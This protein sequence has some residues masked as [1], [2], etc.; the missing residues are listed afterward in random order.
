MAILYG[1]SDG[2]FFRAYH[3]WVW[4]FCA[5]GA[6]AFNISTRDFVIVTGTPSFDKFVTIFL[7]STS[8]AIRATS[9]FLIIIDAM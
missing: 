8:F 9:T 4:A 6:S 5:G 1:K 7:T 3:D 2:P